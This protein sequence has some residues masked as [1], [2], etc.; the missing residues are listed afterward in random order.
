MCL[1]QPVAAA[2][3]HDANFSLHRSKF[4]TWTRTTVFD[5]PI[6]P[7]TKILRVGP[8]LLKLACVHFAK[9]LSA[10]AIRE[11]IIGSTTVT[12]KIVCFRRTVTP[13]FTRKW[14][15]FSATFG[16]QSNV[17]R[18]RNMI[19]GRW[20]RFNGVTPGTVWN[21]HAVNVQNTRCSCLKSKLKR[22]DF[23]RL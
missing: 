21:N 6:S 18:T 12:A 11:R 3:P 5:G 9:A 1:G 2:I 4:H 15:L 13:K 8:G 16:T 22:Q 17:K 7:L 23:Y 19:G 20:R 14:N 10:E